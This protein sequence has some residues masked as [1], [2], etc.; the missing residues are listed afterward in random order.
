VLV[1]GRP[2]GVIAWEPNEIEIT[3]L[4]RGDSAT[5]AIEVLGHRRNSHGPH[6]LAQHN[7]R[8]I[9]PNHYRMPDSR[10]CLEYNFVPCGLMKPPRLIVR[11]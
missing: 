11:K 10:W 4:A 6:H 9:S 8:S 3:D 5:L 7:P 2:A 1:D